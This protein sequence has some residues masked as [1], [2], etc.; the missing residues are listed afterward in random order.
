MKLVNVCTGQVLFW[1]RGGGGGNRGLMWC[2]QHAHTY[3]RERT[4]THSLMEEDPPVAP[5]T[6]NGRRS[7]CPSRLSAVP[8]NVW[9]SERGVNGGPHA[10]DTDTNDSSATE[11]ELISR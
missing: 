5:M 4:T 7:R 3:I 8:R 2:I 1:R 11:D 10:V 6:R 9:G